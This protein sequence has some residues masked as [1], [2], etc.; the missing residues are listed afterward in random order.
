[1]TSDNEGASSCIAF[2]KSQAD[3]ARSRAGGSA[4]FL[5]DCVEEERE[6][7]V[8]AVR[9]RRLY[10]MSLVMTYIAYIR[11]PP[12][13][14]QQQVGWAIQP[15]VADPSPWSGERERET[16]RASETAH[17]PGERKKAS[18]R[19]CMCGCKFRYKYT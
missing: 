10:A 3:R 8:I 9:Y 13:G 12:P 17:S 6:Y 16:E 5:L 11:L 19:E 7:T 1:M 15:G 18:E 4:R 14:S 2:V